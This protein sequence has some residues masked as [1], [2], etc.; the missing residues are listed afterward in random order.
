M[1][2][3]LNPNKILSQE[4]IDKCFDFFD[5]DQSGF[6]SIEE[7]MDIF[8]VNDEKKFEKELKNIPEFE[9]KDEMDKSDFHKLVKKLINFRY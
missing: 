8:K 9:N 4:N 5:V 2:G 3:S 6:I 7:F 1:A